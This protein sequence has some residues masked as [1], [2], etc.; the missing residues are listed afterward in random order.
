MKILV[1]GA[2]G[3]VGA[4]VANEALRAGHDVVGTIRPGSSG[5]RLADFQSRLNLVALDLR[6]AGEVNALMRDHRPDFVVHIAWSGVNNKSRSERLQITDNV[7]T[8][9]QLL[10]AGAE[11]GVSKFVGM[12]SQGE[13]GPLDKKIAETDLPLPTTLYGASKLAV[14]YLTRQLAAQSGLSYAWIRIFSTYGPGDNP[15]WLIPSLINQMLDG[16]RPQTTFGEQL[17]DCLF[18]D[19][20]ATAVVAVATLPAAEGVFNLGSGQPLPVRS[21]VEKIRDLAAPGMELVFGE[22]P[23]R[24]DQVWHMEADIERLTAL[25]GWSPRVNIDA[26]LQATVA[27]H[28]AQ[29]LRQAADSVVSDAQG[30]DNAG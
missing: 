14:H 22:I 24:S 28:R 1:T 19:D 15:H 12:G 26:G 25:T 29:R 30:R 27:W 10:E 9:C 8:S 16:Q 17:W 4:A 13:Y 3:F 7:E 20:I 11:H 23:Y 21:I 18:I 2:G 5:L 6:D